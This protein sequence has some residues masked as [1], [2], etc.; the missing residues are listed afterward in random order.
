MIVPADIKP[1]IYC[2]RF[3]LRIRIAVIRQLRAEKADQ[4]RV[5]LQDLADLIVQLQKIADI[6]GVSALLE[7]KIRL[8]FAGDRFYLS[9]FIDAV[10]IGIAEPQISADLVFGLVVLRS[11]ISILFP[12]G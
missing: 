9:E 11:P 3:Q 8:Q 10:F 12:H 2:Q 1:D 6:I 5:P 7:A 4:L